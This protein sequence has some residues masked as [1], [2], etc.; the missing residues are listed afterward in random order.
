M[1]DIWC[2]KYKKIQVGARSKNVC[3]HLCDILTFCVKRI[4]KTVN[5]EV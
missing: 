4:R 3:Q 2:V 1:R 5:F